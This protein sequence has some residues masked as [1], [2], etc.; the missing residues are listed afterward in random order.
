MPRAPSIGPASLGLLRKGL[1]VCV[2]GG[3]GGLGGGVEKPVACWLSLSPSD[4]RGGMSPAGQAP[5]NEGGV[6]RGR[7][8]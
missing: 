4:A 5:Q 8:P 3:V 6:V 2:C 7:A 1:K